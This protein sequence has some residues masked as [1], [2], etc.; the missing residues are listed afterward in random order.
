MSRRLQLM[1]FVLLIFSHRIIRTEN[2]A[3]I[4]HGRVLG[5]EWVPKGFR[6]VVDMRLRY[7]NRKIENGE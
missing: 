1:N 2:D 4:K 7:Y 6:E 3:S 5:L